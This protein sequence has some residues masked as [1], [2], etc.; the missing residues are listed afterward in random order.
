MLSVVVLA[1]LLGIV[2]VASAQ[3]PGGPPPG[4]YQPSR[5]TISPYLN[6]LRRNAGPIPNYYSLVRPQLQQLDTNQRQ[7]AFNSRQQ[8]AV[9]SLD[10]QVLRIAESPAA[11]TGTGAVFRNYSNYYPSLGQQAPR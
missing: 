8:D 11:P 10:R 4:R 1:T 2:S 3:A 6:L 5:P 7:Q 9:R